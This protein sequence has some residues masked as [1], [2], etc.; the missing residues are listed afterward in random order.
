MTA[1]LGDAHTALP[2]PLSG[3]KL[4]A[5]AIALAMAN[6]IVILDLTIANVSVPHIAGGLAISP[7]QGTWAI[8]SYAVAD[9]IT[10]PLTGWL[11]SRMGLVRC[12]V[13][14]LIGFGLF[15]FL[16]GI[17]RTIE[18]LIAFRI[19]QGLAG[20]PLM[21][22]SQTLLRQIFPPEKM[23]MAMGLW[24]VGTI[25]APIAGPILGGLLSDNFS[26]PWI[27][28]INIPVVALCVVLVARLLAPYET[29]MSRAPIDFVGLAL[30]IVWVSALQ[31]MIDIGREHD[32]FGSTLVVAM[33]VIAGVGFLAFIIWEWHDPHPVVDIRLLADR[34]LAISLTALAVGFCAFYALLVI[35]P[36]WMQQVA[37]YTATDA[38]FVAA[39]SGISAVLFAPLAAALMTRVD[40]RLIISVALLVICGSALMRLSWSLDSNY[41]AF[42]IPQFVQGV[43]MPF[44]AVGLTAITLVTIAPDK[45]A[46]AS[47]IVSFVRSMMGAFGTALSATYWDHSSRQAQ[48]DIVGTLNGSADAL[49][50][51]TQAGLSGAQ[52]VVLLDRMAEAQALT[53]GT[54]SLYTICAAVCALAAGII[55]LV[56]R[57]PRVQGIPMGH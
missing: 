10:V 41:A 49:G 11:V 2:A 30:L 37:G 48:S 19:C 50:A 14:C 3:W 13:V 5:A 22:L 43:G 25:S 31:L 38:G 1:P 20:G 9:A 6:F 21:A 27:F 45:V 16:C 47:G 8:T 32:W 15:S 40:L 35:T 24:A 54:I 52:S 53:L 12:L 4:I 46:S 34:S 17:A 28:F 57:P 39:Y 23:G 7:S 42:A 33:A 51:M 18:L 36:L 26:W 29:A 56:P 44:F 55:W